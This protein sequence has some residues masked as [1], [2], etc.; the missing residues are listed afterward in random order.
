MATGRGRGFSIIE[1]MV[2]LL[3]ASAGIGAIIN[4]FIQLARA[5]ARD[6]GRAQAAALGRGL[7]AEWQALD[8]AAIAILLK[9]APGLFPPEPQPFDQ[10]PAA[11]WQWRWQGDLSPGLPMPLTLYITTARRP[12]GEAVRLPATL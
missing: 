8:R 12:S 3:I 4:H 10:E 6:A 5:A 11:A 9:D 2:A 1:L 7:I